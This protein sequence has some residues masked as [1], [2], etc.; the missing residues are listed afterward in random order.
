[1]KIGI[2]KWHLLLMAVIMVI[3]TLGFS[4]TAV[5]AAQPPPTPSTTGFQIWQKYG[6]A[7]TDNTNYTG[8]L[9]TYMDIIPDGGQALAGW[10]VDQTNY[11]TIGAHYTA[12]I[13]DYFGQWYPAYLTDLTALH[14]KITTNINWFA[15]AYI[16]NHE[17]PGATMWEIQEAIWS[18]TSGG[19]LG[20]EGPAVDFNTTAM[21][22]DANNYL[23]THSGVY[24]PGPGQLAPVIY[25]TN[26]STQLIFF[27]WR[28]PGTPPAPTP[29]LPTIALLGIGLVGLGGFGWLQRKKFISRQSSIINN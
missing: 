19:Y 1:M 15:I 2:K 5:M 17:V 28:I 8:T 4:V 13:F 25:Y 21:I 18:F 14:S 22:N 6:G 11:I 10:C 16:L 24:V 29:E 26:D 3:T 7:Y 12:Q 23:S 9:G 20:L 27:Q